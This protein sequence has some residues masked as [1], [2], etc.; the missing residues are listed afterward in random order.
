MGPDKITPQGAVDLFSADPKKPQPED[1]RGKTSRGLNV[2]TVHPDMVKGAL[3]RNRPSFPGVNL[4]QRSITGPLRNPGLLN[5][6]ASHLRNR[7]DG[8]QRTA[9]RDIYNN[10]ESALEEDGSDSKI[11][12]SEIV[13][14]ELETR[15]N[16]F[17]V[18]TG[19]RGHKICALMVEAGLA[20]SD[21]PKPDSNRV[22]I[23]FIRP[24]DFK[25]QVRAMENLAQLSE[26]RLNTKGG[27]D[28]PLMLK[29][30]SGTQ[31]SWLQQSTLLAKNQEHPDPDWFRQPRLVHQLEQLT[32]EKN[33]R[34]KTARELAQLKPQQSHENQWDI[35]RR[36]M[37][38]LSKVA[39][40]AGVY[41]IGNI[42][43]NH[44]R[45]L[46]LYTTAEWLDVVSQIDDVDP[47]FAEELRAVAPEF[48]VSDHSKL[49]T[50]PVR[51]PPA[52]QEL[53]DYL[54]QHNLLNTK[55]TT[56]D[57]SLIEDNNE[58]SP[59]FPLLESFW[60]GMRDKKKRTLSAQFK[61]L[62]L[63]KNT[64]VT[65]G[66][67]QQGLNKLKQED[68]DL[69]G[70][71]L[72]NEQRQAAL[73][74]AQQRIKRDKEIKTE[75]AAYGRDKKH[76]VAP[77]LSSE[78]IIPDQLNTNLSGDD[79]PPET[80]IRESL[81]SRKILSLM[82]A[83]DQV[84]TLLSKSGKEAASLDQLLEVSVD[85]VFTEGEALTLQEWQKGIQ[86]TP[87]SEQPIP[88]QPAPLIPENKHRSASP[89][90]SPVRLS[91]RKVAE[92]HYK[93]AR[94]PR[95][96]SKQK[97]TPLGRREGYLGQHS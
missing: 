73:S 90:Q 84:V 85:E 72:D 69:Y 93:E 51:E 48:Q 75:L 77:L 33:R 70:Q 39:R 50:Q 35:A 94:I 68:P 14:S 78:L 91:E 10:L 56:D 16:S 63:P 38:E 28:W 64:P 81:S 57:V 47:L 1:I 34:E 11:V 26:L 37:N 12:A 79:A 87:L 3:P 13:A 42:L 29:I 95:D 54:S 25:L 55:V 83:Y 74:K 7:P 46:S 41:E 20:R 19:S 40:N 76:L 58:A 49:T 65:L 21:S 92:V 82:Q 17:T 71:C 61:H 88:E 44:T 43:V 53:K 62:D 5:R 4:K 6:T 2:S 67:I 31:H 32:S 9:L 36:R 24:R 89:V 80:K 52:E 66:R 60:H 59:A 8:S 86:N 97:R 27:L 18:N 15:A 96:T 23:H 22:T 30:D 45:R